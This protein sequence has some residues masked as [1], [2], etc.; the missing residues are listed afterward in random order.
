MYSMLE[1]E[2]FDSGHP[3]I[4]LLQ[5][6]RPG[7]LHLMPEKKWVSFLHMAI[8]DICGTHNMYVLSERS[9]VIQCTED[10][11]LGKYYVA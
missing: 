4:Y 9:A 8:Y 7:D 3:R 2:P 6:R 1:A 5:A 11:L 10:Y